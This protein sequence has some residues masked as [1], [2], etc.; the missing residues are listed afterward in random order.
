MTQSLGAI[1]LVMALLGGALF[2]L[3]KRGAATFSMPRLP[4][5]SA[6]PREMEVLERVTLAPQHALHL[7]RVGDRRLLVATTPSSCQ[8][9]SQGER[10]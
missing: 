9:I 10:A 2:L 7:V 4:R 5:M 8:V 6:A 3:K 1:L